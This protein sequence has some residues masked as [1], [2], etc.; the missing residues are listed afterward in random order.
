MRYMAES[1]KVTVR[2]APE[3]V[4]RLQRIADK[5]WMTPS[6]VLR[7]YIVNDSM[8][9]EDTDVGKDKNA[10]PLMSEDDDCREFAESAEERRGKDGRYKKGGLFFV[11]PCLPWKG[12]DA[13]RGIKNP[14]T[15]VVWSVNDKYKAEMENER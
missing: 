9:D 6:Q 14:T 12:L 13:R 4:E 15:L 7:D 11:L 10:P 2:L 8:G 1:K 5:R 3:L